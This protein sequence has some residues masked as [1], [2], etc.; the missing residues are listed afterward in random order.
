[1]VIG[2]S[3]AEMKSVI[4]FVAHM[5]ET[6]WQRSQV[7]TQLMVLYLLLPFSWYVLSY[8]LQAVATSSQTLVHMSGF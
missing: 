8:S 6:P 1:M 4:N 7:Q 3:I 2:H 5:A